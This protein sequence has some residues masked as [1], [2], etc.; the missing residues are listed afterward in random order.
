MG[1]SLEVTSVRVFNRDEFVNLVCIYRAP[2]S[3]CE[4]FFV[5]LEYLLSKVGD[6]SIF[7][8]DFNLNMKPMSSR[9]RDLLDSFEAFGYRMCFSEYSRVHAG[10]S[11]LIDNIFLSFDVFFDG[12]TD[13]TFL[14]DHRVQS[15][16]ITECFS[17]VD[18]VG[19]QATYH[20]RSY[21]CDN[22]D[23]FRHLL[24]NG[25]WA[26]LYNEVNVERKF[27]VFFEAF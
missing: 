8:G 3:N 24:S 14:S 2:S 7:A 1:D 9:G 25:S 16:R 20:K 27:T 11:S 22:V 13:D 15:L 19:D 10:S 5:S 18:F 23:Y 17:R 26:S 12:T 21:S 6:R 4:L